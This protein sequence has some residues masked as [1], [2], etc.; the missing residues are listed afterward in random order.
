MER[1][2]PDLELIK[3]L[4]KDCFM[5]ITVGGGVTCIK[6]VEDLL[7]AGADKVAIG[8]ATQDMKLVESMAKRFG[9]QAIVVS[10]DYR[11]SPYGPAAYVHN[12]EHGYGNAVALAVNLA[13]AGAGEV[14]LTSIN[15]EGMMAG[16]DLKTLKDVCER[17]SV[18]VIAHGGCGMYED[19]HGAIQAGAHAVAAGSLFQFTDST[20]RGAAEYLKT[21]GVEVRLEV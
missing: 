17:T 7:N 16:Y 18:P 1:R 3:E 13:N 14:L 12:G 20:P 11:E 2:G 8:S 10:V 4:T 15:R 6:D 19:M 5:P 9:C 21:K